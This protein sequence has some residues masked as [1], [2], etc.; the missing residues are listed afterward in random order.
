MEVSPH[1]SFAGRVCEFAGFHITDCD[2]GV[3]LHRPLKHTGNLRDKTFSL[4]FLDSLGPKLRRLNPKKWENIIRLYNGTRSLRN[5]DLSP[6]VNLK[7]SF[8]E[9]DHRFR[10]TRDLIRGTLNEIFLIGGATVDITDLHDLDQLYYSGPRKRKSY[11]SR[12]QFLTEGQ[13][14]LREVENLFRRS[15]KS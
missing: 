7:S 9:S 4:D 14:D 15:H 10:L 6:K 1:K 13:N 5:P 2:R 8:D 12:I 11:T 3:S